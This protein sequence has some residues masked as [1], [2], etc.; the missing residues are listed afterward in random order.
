MNPDLKIEQVDR[1]QAGGLGQRSTSTRSMESSSQI[2]AVMAIV[3]R[4]AKVKE[5]SLLLGTIKG[6]PAGVTA[7]FRTGKVCGAYCV[8]THRELEGEARRQH[9]ARVLPQGGGRGREETRPADHPL[10]LPGGALPEA[11][12][13]ESLPQGPLRERR[14]RVPDDKGSRERRGR[15]PATASTGRRARGRSPSSR[16]SS[17][18]RPSRP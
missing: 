17:A 9:D 16:S 6:K 4:L 15:L 7:L 1:E 8:A 10:G 13:Q 14:G 2:K 11:R 5:A 18:S 12:V 3:Q